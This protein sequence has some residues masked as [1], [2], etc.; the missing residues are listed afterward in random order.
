MDLC[1]SYWCVVSR[2]RTQPL[3]PNVGNCTLEWSGMPACSPFTLT[4]LLLGRR[5]SARVPCA[6]EN[7]LAG[8]RAWSRSLVWHCASL[9]LVCLILLQHFVLFPLIDNVLTLSFDLAH[10]ARLGF[11]TRSPKNVALCLLRDSG[12][13]VLRAKSVVAI[14]RKNYRAPLMG[15]VIRALER[16]MEAARIR[17][18]RRG[19]GK[20]QRLGYVSYHLMTG[21]L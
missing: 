19:T 7:Y 11:A 14:L 13:L 3:V 2:I 20:L 12:L 21:T 17:L 5:L 6:P 18:V 15:S 8:F 10:Q 4:P 1:D 9:F 16:G